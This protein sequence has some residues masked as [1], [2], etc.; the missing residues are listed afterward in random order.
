MYFQFWNLNEPL[1][2]KWFTYVTFAVSWKG[3]LYVIATDYNSYVIFKVCDN[4]S[5]QRK[6][7]S[8]ECFK[9]A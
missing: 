6:Y 8:C 9:I 1:Y 7:L 3:G 2:I 4:I 5:D